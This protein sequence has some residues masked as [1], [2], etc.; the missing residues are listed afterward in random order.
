MFIIFSQ[1]ISPSGQCFVCQTAVLPVRFPQ[2]RLC[3]DGSHGFQNNVCRRC[4]FTIRHKWKV[5]VPVPIL[6]KSFRQ[7]ARSIPTHNVSHPFCQKRKPP[8]T[9][10]ILSGT[11]GRGKEAITAHITHKPSELPY[12]RIRI[13]GTRTVLWQY[14]IRPIIRHKTQEP[15]QIPP[16]PDFRESPFPRVF[17]RLCEKDSPLS[18][19]RKRENTFGKGNTEMAPQYIFYWKMRAGSDK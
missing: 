19:K 17:S 1:Q 3:P 18:D 15:V 8:A 11:T 12:L 2:G 5:S 14:G 9:Y 7:T 16:G 6:S 10:N 13:Y 4:R